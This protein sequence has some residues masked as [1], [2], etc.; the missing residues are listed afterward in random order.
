MKNK[1]EVLS[2]FKIWQKRAECYTGHKTRVLRSDNGGEYLSH[3][4]KDHLMEHGIS[5]QLT[6]PYTPQQNGAAER[7]NRTL[8]NSTR[9]IL[10][11]MNC[12][13]KFGPKQSPPLAISR[14]IGSLLPDCP[15]TPLHTKYGSARN[16]M[17]VIT[18]V[19]FKVLVHGSEGKHQNV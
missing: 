4:F 15:I 2:C 14:N 10:K 6:F 7:L 16:P 8:L 1:S 17:L 11:H 3:A 9:S 18:G 13:K 12:D 5:H 19:W